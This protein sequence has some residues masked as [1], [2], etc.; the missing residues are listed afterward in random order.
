MRVLVNGGTGFIGG[1][2]AAALATRGHDVRV[3]SRHGRATP[4]ADPRVRPVRG[5]VLEPKTLDAPLEGCDAVVHAVQFPNHPIEN[6]R[7][8]HTYERF[9]G[10][11]TTNA[12]EAAIRA[13]VG[14]FVY[15]SGAG[16]RAGRTEPWYRAKWRAEE[17]VRASG[18]A[19][20]IFRPSWVYGPR[21]RSL[22]KFVT[23]ARRLPFVPVIGGGRERVRPLY[24]R[25]LAEAV[26]RSIDHAGAPLRALDAGGPERLTMNEILRTTLRVLGVRR[27][28]FHSPAWAM[29]AAAS[30]LQ[31]LPN[32]PLT[33]QAIDFIRQEEEVDPRPLEEAFGM[34]M[35]TLEQGL[36]EYLSGTGGHDKTP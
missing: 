23:F 33:P 14:R 36:R 28:L 4:D 22:N 16:V 35:R 26:A 25:D 19:W 6:P 18:A 15:L 5:D 13:G 27:P 30:V 12:V 24:V 29:K 7:R 21:D 17:A 31:F 11:G 3:L 9:D 8:G 10:Q 32:P 34:R 2:I 1:E 20:T